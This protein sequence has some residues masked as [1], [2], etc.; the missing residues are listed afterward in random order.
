MESKTNAI[1][2][3]LKP[4]L[5]PVSLGART[6]RTFARD[7]RMASQPHIGV[8]GAG[9]A[10]LRCADV[11]LQRGFQVTVLEGRNRIGGRV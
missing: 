6:I 8:I 5:I 1:G 2:T 7:A 3:G 9:I 4:R 11:L 10:G